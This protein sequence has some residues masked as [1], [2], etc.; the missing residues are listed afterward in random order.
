MTTNVQNRY[1]EI[2]ENADKIYCRLIGPE[3][4]KENLTS[5]PGEEFLDLGIVYDL[6]LQTPGE[7]R[8]SMRIT[9]YHLHKWNMT[10]E[11]VRTLAWEN[12]LRDQKED[13]CSLSRI[14]SESGFSVPS[15]EDGLYV[16]T[17]TDRYYGA[18]CIA[19]PG[20]LSRIAGE[21]GGDYYVLP[22]SIH[23]CLMIRCE[24]YLQAD[25]LRKLVAGIN[26][27]ELQPADILSY[28]V[29]RYL[30]SEDRLIIDNS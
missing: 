12:T 1:E 10:A 7:E 30:K 13:F 15:D 16:L 3:R 25:G 14:L 28:S 27:T 6:R 19:Y 9:D 20:I 4:R 5:G 21:L 8:L 17:N 22:S 18:V 24:E 2:G 11:Q 23:E 29:Y 26:D